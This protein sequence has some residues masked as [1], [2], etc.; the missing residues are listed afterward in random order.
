MSI[1]RRFARSL[2]SFASNQN[3]SMSVIFALA[4]LPLFAAVGAAVDFSRYASVQ[5]EVQTALDAATLQGAA[6]LGASNA[7]RETIAAGVFKSN[8]DADLV[9]SAT[10]KAEHGVLEGEAEIEVPTS[11]MQLVG[12][13][14]MTV[15]ADNQVNLNS[16]KKVE[17]A[18]VLDYS[19]SMTDE[20]RGGPKYKAMGAA[21]MKL[22]DDL[23]KLEKGKFK[24]G[25]VP[26]SHHVYVSMPGKYVLGENASSSWTGCTVDRLGPYNTTNAVPLS[27]D[28]STKWGQPQATKALDGNKQVQG[29]IDGQTYY[30]CN[31]P[32]NNDGYAAHNLKIRPLST[33]IAGAKSQI[34]RM[35]PYAYTHISL[36]VEFGYQMLSPSNALDSDAASFGDDTVEKYLVVLTDG[37]QTVPAYNNKTNNLGQAS[38]DQGESN[39]A[40][41]C[42]SAKGDGIK[43]ITMAFDLTDKSKGEQDIKDRLKACASKNEYYFDAKDG[44]DL[45][46]AFKT[47]TNEIAQ[48][49]FLSK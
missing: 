29:W 3:G 43:V 21:A 7:K 14:T 11:F 40:A 42:A 4:T 41:L 46:Q 48:N 31:G 13:N 45:T 27:S 39:L 5:A 12:I 6:A 18:L 8:L 15:K 23:E 47:I 33:D 44:I 9:A 16:P 22:M 34:A 19:G 36:G 30:D 49:I 24:V 20:V 35:V 17:I 1:T 37:S 25:L 28:D 10:F 38:V 2:K 32:H 26:F